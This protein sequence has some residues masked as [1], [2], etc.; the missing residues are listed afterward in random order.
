MI[1]LC[2]L[3]A[4]VAA[5]IDGG[6]RNG[7]ADAGARIESLEKGLAEEREFSTRLAEEIDTAVAACKDGGASKGGA[8]AVARI[9]SL[10]NEVTEEREYS[11]R[12][13]EEVDNGGASKGG[14]DAGARIESLEKEVAEEREYSARLAEEVDSMKALLGLLVKMEVLARGVLLLRPGLRAFRRRI[15]SLQKEVAEEREYSARLAEEVVSMKALGD[16]KGRGGGQYEGLAVAAFKDGG[17]RNGDAVAGARIQSLEKEVAEER[18]YLVRL[19]EEVDSMKAL[20][21]SGVREQLSMMKELYEEE[22]QF[23]VQ[24]KEQLEAEKALNAELK[25]GPD[26]RGKGEHS[27]SQHLDAVAAGKYGGASKG[28]AIAGA[29]IENLEKQMAQESECAAKLAEEMPGWVAANSSDVGASSAASAELQSLLDQALADLSHKSSLLEDL[30]AQLQVAESRLAAVQLNADESAAAAAAQLAESAE[31]TSQLQQQVSEAEASI[32]SLRQ[33]VNDAQAELEAEQSAH[34]AVTDAQA[35]LEAEQIAHQETMAMLEVKLQAL[36]GRNDRLAHEEEEEKQQVDDLERLLQERAARAATEGSLLTLHASLTKAEGEVARSMSLQ[37]ELRS[38]LNSAAQQLVSAE[39]GNEHEVDS[40]RASTTHQLQAAVQ[41]AEDKLSI[42]TADVIRL[43]GSLEASTAEL[44]ELAKSK[45][46]DAALLAE[47][48][49]QLEQAEGDSQP[50]EASQLSQRLA[51]STAELSEARS[52]Y[53]ALVSEHDAQLASLSAQY[54]EVVTALYDERKQREAHHASESNGAAELQKEMESVLK[55]KEEEIS[56]NT[57]YLAER[58]EFW[59]RELSSKAVGQTEVEV[60]Y[61]QTL[62]QLEREQSNY[63]ILLLDLDRLKLELSQSKADLTA[64]VLRLELGSTWANLGIWAVPGHLGGTWASGQYMGIW[65]KEL[66]ATQLD[67]ERAHSQAASYEHEHELENEM[68]VVKKEYTRVV[69]DNKKLIAQM[70]QLG[71]G[72]SEAAALQMEQLSQGTSEAAALQVSLLQLRSELADTQETLQ[73]ANE[74]RQGLWLKLHDAESRVERQVQQEVFPGVACA[75]AARATPALA[76]SGPADVSQVEDAPALAGAGPADVSQVE[77]APALAGARPAEES[78]VEDGAPLAPSNPLLEQRIAELE[79]SLAAGA[80]LVSSNL[81]LEQRAAKLEDSLAAGEGA[82]VAP[83]NLLVEQRIAELEE[84]LAAGAT[85]APSNPLLEQRIAELEESLAAGDDERERLK[86]QLTPSNPHHP[87]HTTA[88]PPPIY[89]PA[90]GATVAP[91]NPLLEQRITELEESLAAGDDERERLKSQLQRLKMQMMTEQE[92]EEEKVGWR[93]EAELTQAAETHAKEMAQL[94]AAQ[95]GERA[96]LRAE[97]AETYAQEMAKLLAAQEGERAALGAEAAETLAQEMA[98]LL[99]AQEGEKAELGA[100]EM[101]QLLAEGGKAAQEGERATLGA[102]VERLT[103]ELAKAVAASSRMLSESDNWEEI[104]ADKDRE[105]ANLQAALGELTYESEA[106]EKLRY[107]V[108]ATAAR[109]H[110]V[111]Q[112]LAASKQT[113]EVERSARDASDKKALETLEV[114]MSGGDAFDK[115]ALTSEECSMLRKALDQAMAQVQAMRGDN[116]SMVDRRIIVKL[117]L[118]YFEKGSSKDVLSLMA[119]MLNMTE[120]EKGKVGLLGGQRRGF[121]RSAAYMPFSLVQGASRALTTRP[122]APA[123]KEGAASLA[124]Q[125]VNFL[126]S[127]SELDNEATYALAAATHDVSHS[128]S[129]HEAS[130]SFT[131]SR[132]ADQA[133]AT[134]VTP[135]STSYTAMGS[136]DRQPATADAYSYSSTRSEPPPP[137]NVPSFLAGQPHPP[138]PQRLSQSSFLTGQQSPN[139]YSSLSG[140]QAPS[141]SSSLST[142]QAPNQSSSLSGQQLP[143]QSSFLSS[144][145]APNQS[146]FLSGQQPP[147]QSSSLTGQQMPSQSSSLSGQQA[148]NQYSFLSGQQAPSQSTSLSGQ[149]APT[150]SVSRPPVYPYGNSTPSAPHASTTT[151]SAP[152]AVEPPLPPPP[153]FN[154]SIPF[155]QPYIHAQPSEPA[156]SA[157]QPSLPPPPPPTYGNSSSQPYHQPLPSYMTAPRPDSAPFGSPT[158]GPPTRGDP[159]RQS[160]PTFQL[161]G[162]P[163]TPGPIAYPNHYTGTP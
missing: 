48:Q 108:R 106:A 24:C 74:E 40:A 146:S 34:Q 159:M 86:F 142:Q 152:H 32:A 134:T 139:Q 70:E 125:W 12:L 126:L 15:E 163:S 80:T 1:Y 4:A 145:Q 155:S 61:R 140:Q 135:S 150:P 99:G 113:L 103:D 22:H 90:T 119:R 10:E 77:D 62:D 50:A 138:P 19:A 9:E 115:K 157:P 2:V 73:L 45:G 124:D 5:D 60:R 6:A 11:A 25:V 81:L 136:A 161:D 31:T 68:A 82:T 78:Q 101:A 76:G 153:S 162:P 102:E 49:Q 93:V 112:E 57:A 107:E 28:G 17:A 35:E 148:Q 64:Q 104:L 131:A 13:G 160:L 55:Q 72:T 158:P 97:V 69:S 54:D 114:E 147:N 42:A 120:E 130:R 51:A 3:G 85:V 8:V 14:A 75:T 27:G 121:L 105:V 47:R 144:Q 156:Q 96:A 110:E 16:Y 117:L 71:Q 66:E 118:T 149:H 33:A 92:D 143:N 88:S 151:T 89:P 39:A 127:Q 116:N 94:L 87:T 63:N 154:S 141:Q 65:A 52:R 36:K 46:R 37:Q 132:E 100:E 123:V 43:T 137:A 79:E 38:Q 18:E 109:L 95:E 21:E 133:P 84:S 98:Q 83:S 29:R 41:D 44:A 30:T 7:G 129:F 26:T 111:H 59:K 128:A 67:L 91:S 23:S 56:R 122:A 53:K 20:D 58:D